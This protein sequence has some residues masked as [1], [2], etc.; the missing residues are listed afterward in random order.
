MTGEKNMSKATALEPA[1]EEP[2]DK[3]DNVGYISGLVHELFEV[4]KMHLSKK[5]FESMLV[6]TENGVYTL[7]KLQKAVETIACEL[8]SVWDSDNVN[9]MLLTISESIDASVAMIETGREA[10]DWSD[11]YE[12]RRAFRAKLG[13]ERP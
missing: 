2:S 8:D 3:I 11:N 12:E 6:C 7:K 10:K 13:E 5:D 4:A 9:A 1:F